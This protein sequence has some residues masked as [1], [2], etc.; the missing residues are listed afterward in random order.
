VARAAA[1]FQAIVGTL[2][3]PESTHKT[4]Y[5]LL[6]ANRVY[7]VASDAAEAAVL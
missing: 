1:L 3:P 7:D 6:I 5:N 2:P 4:V